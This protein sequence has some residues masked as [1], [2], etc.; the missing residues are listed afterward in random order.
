MYKE[1]FEIVS[2]EV[3]W[4]VRGSYQTICYTFFKCSNFVMTTLRVFFVKI[5]S[6]PDEELFSETAV[7][8]TA[9][10]FV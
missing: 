1:T 10:Y 8:C 7:G 4:S 3:L 9:S 5:I 2:K 6:I